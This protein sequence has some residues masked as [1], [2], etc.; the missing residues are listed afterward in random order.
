[1]LAVLSLILHIRFRMNRSDDNSEK[2]HSSL[3]RS[4][5][6][7]A[8]KRKDR[9]YPRREALLQP[10]EPGNDYKDSPG[11]FRGAFQYAVHDRA[12]DGIAFHFNSIAG[13]HAGIE[14]SIQDILEAIFTAHAFSG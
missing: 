14:R 4:N 5:P 1:M 10:D 13:P 6:E 8:R 3:K 12:S 11:M 7:T 9:Q 2:L